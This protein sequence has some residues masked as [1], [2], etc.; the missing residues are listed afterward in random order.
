[1]L[2]HLVTAVLYW[3]AIG[4]T[5]WAIFDPARF[6]DRALAWYIAKRGKLPSTLWMLT[7]HIAVIVAGPV[8]VLV[9]LRH[10]HRRVWF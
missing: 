8:L 4:T 2:D 10:L 9:V 5:F 3:L 7:A 6:D 1:M